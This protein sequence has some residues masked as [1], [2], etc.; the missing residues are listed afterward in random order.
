MLAQIKRTGLLVFSILKQHLTYRNFFTRIFSSP[1]VDQCL[2]FHDIVGFRTID[3]LIGHIDLSLSEVM[4][5]TQNVHEVTLE[6]HVK[7]I[8]R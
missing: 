2:R 4:K 6:I 3:Q 7:N 1:M 5:E 8:V